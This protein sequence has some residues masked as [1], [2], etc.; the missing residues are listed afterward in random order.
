M[1][2]MT[3]VL[4]SSFFCLHVAYFT[5]GEI[6]LSL[7][8]DVKPYKFLNYRFSNKLECNISSEIPSN[9]VLKWFKDDKLFEPTENKFEMKDTHLVIRRTDDNDM[10]DYMCAL[11]EKEDNK[12][13]VYRSEVMTCL[14]KPTSK[15]VVVPPT[16]NPVD[17]GSK[18]KLECIVQGKPSPL[19]HWRKEDK[20]LQSGGRFLISDVVLEN[21]A[22]PNAYLEISE[23]EME[24]RGNYYCTAQNTVT[25]H[26][27]GTDGEIFVR[28]KDRFAALWP[29]VGICAEVLVLCIIIFFYEQ[30]RN[31]SELDES[32]TDQS[33]EQKNTPDHG[34]DTVRQRK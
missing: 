26:I 27:N 20:R 22:V 13:I 5:S 32:D 1:D 12:K 34:K 21:K 14:G 24:D 16:S 25:D 2:R 6:T 11:V 30:K 28:V 8:Y 18:I 17:E 3:K 15:I 33:P 7:N 10:T 29:F 23:V 9:L 31:K 19:V 4:F